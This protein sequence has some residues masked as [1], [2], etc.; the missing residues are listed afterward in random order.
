MNNLVLLCPFHHR[1]V[2]EGGWGVEMDEWGAPRF[3]NPLDARVPEVPAA[4]DIGTLLP[5]GDSSIDPPASP[6]QDFGLAGWHGRDG[7]DAWTATTLWT[8][9][10]VDWDW[11]MLCLW[12]DGGERRRE[13]GHTSQP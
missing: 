7:I 1:A 6:A 13:G 3:F 11:A 4:S 12:R 2:H 8:G 10:R 5:G 9:E